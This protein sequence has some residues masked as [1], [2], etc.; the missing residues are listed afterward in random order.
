VGCLVQV[1]FTGII[2]AQMFIDIAAHGINDSSGRPRWEAVIVTLLLAP[3]LSYVLLLF[4]GAIV[5]WDRC[6]R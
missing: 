4:I 1:V 2:Y 3:L 6:R 5:R